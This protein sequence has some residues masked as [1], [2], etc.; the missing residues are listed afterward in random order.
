M[1]L[2]DSARR[3]KTLRVV[4]IGFRPR[5]VALPLTRPFAVGP[6]DLTMVELPTL[7]EPVAVQANRRCPRRDD[8]AAAFALLEQARAGVL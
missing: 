5:D 2:A 7:L 4:R 6:L 8:R 1:T 3:P